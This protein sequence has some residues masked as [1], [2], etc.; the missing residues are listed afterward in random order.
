MIEGVQVKQLTTH[1][2]E[3]G[4]FREVIRETD[5]FF[6]HFGQWSHSLMYAGTA[7]AWHVHW[8]QTDWWYV[9]GALKVV[10][11][12]LR[13]GSSTKGC[14]LEL[15]MGESYDPV[16]LKI[17]PGVAH[18]CRALELTHL[19]YVTSNVYDPSDEGRIPPDDPAIGYDW[20]ASPEIK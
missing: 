6:D 10:L 12:D 2:D 19:L 16:C 17:P 9:I 11:H 14:T 1:S 7:K 20:T 13:E 4:F 8:H 15:L 5:E 3:R 18:G